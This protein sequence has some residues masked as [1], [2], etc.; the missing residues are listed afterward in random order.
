MTDEDKV[1]NRYRSALHGATPGART[2]AN[3]AG[4]AFSSVL[5]ALT[6][7]AWVSTTADAFSKTCTE[8]QTKAGNA[9]DSCVEEMTSRY[10]REPAKVDPSDYRATWY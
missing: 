3:A 10:S 1:E 8:M 7:E 4:S 6:N 2:R 9:G 5:S